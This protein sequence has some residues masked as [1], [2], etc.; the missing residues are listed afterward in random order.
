MGGCD[1]AEQVDALTR[2]VEVLEE[3]SRASAKSLDELKDE[4]AS[5]QTT[6]LL[7]ASEIH[8]KSNTKIEELEASVASLEARLDELE[9]GGT[10]TPA[11]KPTVAPTG[12]PD[13]AERYRVEI[14]GSA[15]KGRSDA[16]VTIVMISDYQ[17]PFCK[18]AHDTMSTLERDYGDDVRFVAKHNP[19]PFHAQAKPAALAAEAA[20]EQDKFWEM[21]DLL[22]EEGRKLAGADFAALAKRAGCNKS[23]FKSDLKDR[24]HAR[25]IDDDQALAERLGARGTPSFFINGRHLAGAQPVDA[26]KR[27]IDEE[28]ENAE[29]MVSDGTAS[30][31]IY[32]TLMRGAKSSP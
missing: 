10:P 11:P 21:H 16:K 3:Q 26:F 9:A 12:R 27:V 20:R 18:R 23:T 4:V 28:L 19:L 29:Q 31:Q 13:P 15:T 8:D 5:E 17:C 14:D 32:E 24:K 7:R 6:M 22:Y 2:K 30:D 1:G 25:R